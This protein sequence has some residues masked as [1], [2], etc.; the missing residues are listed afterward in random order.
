MSLEPLCKKCG[1]TAGS[2][3]DRLQ[4]GPQLPSLVADGG[5]YLHLVP[6]DP[7][8][9]V[10]SA[11]RA[12]SERRVFIVRTDLFFLSLV[13]CSTNSATLQVTLYCLCPG[14]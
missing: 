13:Y 5:R 4:W 1:A 12:L 6:R 7:D 14:S 9:V 10:W 3:L 8:L 11:L 2:Q